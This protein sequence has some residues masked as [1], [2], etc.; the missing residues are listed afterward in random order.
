MVVAYFLQDE[1]KAKA[2]VEEITE[3]KE[4]DTSAAKPGIL[5]HRVTTPLLPG[6][7]SVCRRP[8]ILNDHKAAEYTS[9]HCECN[10]SCHSEVSTMDTA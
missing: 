10:C 7:P 5:I 6:C 2:K 3:T 4:N 9:L 1:L 8:V